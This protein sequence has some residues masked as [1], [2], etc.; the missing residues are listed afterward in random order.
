[1]TFH[2]YIYMGWLFVASVDEYEVAHHWDAKYHCSERFKTRADANAFYEKLPKGATRAI[3]GVMPGMFGDEVIRVVDGWYADD[4][5]KKRI[6]DYGERGIRD[7][8]W[9]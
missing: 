4:K 5:W 7:E 6:V 8:K 1:M 3:F 2:I 9:R